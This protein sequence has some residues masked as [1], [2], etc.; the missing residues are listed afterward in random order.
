M[1]KYAFFMTGCESWLDV[2]KMLYSNNI[3]EPVFWLGDERHS[4]EANNLFGKDVVHSMDELIHYPYKIN[5]IE[6]SSEE[7]DFFF[8]Q[9]YNRIKDRCT[10]M[11]DRVDS[12]G[13]F[14]R[15]D[16]EVVFQ[17]ISIWALKK[18][19]LSKPDVLI[20]SDSPHSHAQYLI[21][22][23]AL[24]C[25]IPVYKFNTFMP[26]PLLFL[27]NIETGSKV[28]KS[29]PFDK[30]ND[31]NFEDKLSKYVSNIYNSYQK[32]SSYEHEFMARQRLSNQLTKR[33]S[34]FFK[35]GLRKIA[36]ELKQ[37]FL[38]RVDNEYY[39]INPSRLNIFTRLKMKRMKKNNLKINCDK[40]SQDY[41][42][43][44]KFVY[45]ALM[46]EPER[47]TNPDGGDF[48]EQLLAILKLRDLVPKNIEIFVKEHPSQFYL[49]ERGAKG[50]SPMFYNLIKNIEG[51]RFIGPFEDSNN[52]IK[53]AIFST[54]ITGTVALES[55][56]IGK[57]GL[58]FGNTWFIGCPNVISWNQNI[59]Y[60]QIIANE[61]VD[62]GKVL[63]FLKEIYEK[64]CV[65]GCQNISAQQ[66]FSDYLNEDFKSL[67]AEGIYHLMENCFNQLPKNN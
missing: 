31:Y 4:E 52:F 64:N 51:I 25:G 18:L 41:D 43:S 45:F 26:L 63:N 13:S 19:S 7:V 62:A 35:F 22:E 53:H 21:Y 65:L 6:Y 66:R 55:A 10:K 15:L 54:S 30:L 3:A 33:L 47:T 60:D 50:R 9:N 24:Y 44:S 2:A 58:I 57:R 67:E 61:N 11:M 36:G 5:N 46:H 37:D 16:R 17:K 39:H 27:E 38:R 40:N 12:Y 29:I 28:K 48:H 56:I 34:T 59:T 20:M 8:S 49:E 32:T 14:N 42:L 1:K 23:I